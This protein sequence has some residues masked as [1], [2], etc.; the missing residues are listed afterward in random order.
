MSRGSS[1]HC[2]GGRGAARPD[3]QGVMGATFEPGVRVS[4]HLL[5]EEIGRGGFSRVFR[6]EPDGGGAAVAIKV[7]V[8]PEL[9][10]ALRAE[11]AVL[12]RLQGPH[13]VH[14]IAE[15]LDEDPPYFV[16]ELCEGGD[17][18]AKLDAAEGRRLPVAEALGLMEA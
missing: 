16:L 8:R 12:R 6:A 3:S 5:S 10:S 2:P 13:F 18:R 17:L 1:L 9:V 4:G 14:I 11:G 7:A 15:H